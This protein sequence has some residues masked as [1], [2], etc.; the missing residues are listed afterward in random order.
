MIDQSI[1]LG[2]WDSEGG[3][4]C[5]LPRCCRHRWLTGV[6]WSSTTPPT[7]HTSSQTYLHTKTNKE[8]A[9][10]KTKLNTKTRAK[11]DVAWSS[12][13]QPTSHTSTPHSY[14]PTY[15]IPSYLLE[16]QK[17]RGNFFG[18]NHDDKWVPKKIK[19]INS[20]LK[21]W[22]RLKDKLFKQN[23]Q[24]K[25]RDIPFFFI[26]FLLEHNL[27]KGPQPKIGNFSWL[28]P[29]GVEPPLMAFF[30]SNF[31]PIIFFCN[32]ILHIWNEFYIWS[33][34][35][36]LLPQ[37]IENCSCQFWIELVGDS[38]KDLRF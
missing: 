10:T 5:G 30:L 34:S 32:G 35:L 37:K 9:K 11:T 19:P 13:T 14:L 2:W 27:G 7:S 4:P 31:Y 22:G 25:R 15:P 3:Y 28:M 38:K 23:E 33:Q 12:T 26:I 21:K 8:T 6:A 16:S 24:T 17:L 18:N 20:L 1:G 29:L 36:P